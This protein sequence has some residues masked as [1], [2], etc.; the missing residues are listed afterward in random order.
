MTS[1]TT[2]VATLDSILA[3]VR[4]DRA[5]FGE[6]TKNRRGGGKRMRLMRSRMLL[7]QGGICPKCGEGIV[8]GLLS[9]GPN[10][11][12]EA[13]V[14][15]HLVPQSYFGAE[16]ATGGDRGGYVDGNMSVWHKRCNDSHGERDTN[17]ADL[18]RPDVVFI[19]DWKSLPF[20]PK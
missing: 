11:D 2:A 5:T 20:M 15:A 16:G 12:P 14:W 17:A 1:T 8:D 13:G 7:A 4:A 9:Y 19:A 10:A 18:A 3:N 6:F